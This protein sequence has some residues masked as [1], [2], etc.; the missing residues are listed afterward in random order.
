MKCSGFNQK[1]YKE[2]ERSQTEWKDNRCKC[3]DDIDFKL[4]Y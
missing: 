3:Q 1:L 4:T 2:P